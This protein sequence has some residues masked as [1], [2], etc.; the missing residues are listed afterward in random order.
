MPG[1]LGTGAAG[2]VAVWRARVR[3]DELL[4]GSA[5]IMAS[6]MVTSLIGYEIGRAHV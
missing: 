3:G 4:R 2:V 6:S 1:R 5:F